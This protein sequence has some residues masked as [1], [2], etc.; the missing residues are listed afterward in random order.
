MAVDAGYLYFI[1]YRDSVPGLYRIGRGGGSAGLVAGG[2]F[3]SAPIAVDDTSVYAVLDGD[4]GAPGMVA[5]VVAYDKANGNPTIL[6]TGERSFAPSAAAGSA[7]KAQLAIDATHVYWTAADDAALPTKLGRIMRVPKG[8]GAK[9]I[10]ADQQPGAYGVA[11]D[12]GFVYWT[13]STAIKRI[14]K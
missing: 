9:E 10:L 12:A 13:T 8:G 1:G 14:P 6:A 11:I 5:T 4:E 3:N 2:N 7:R